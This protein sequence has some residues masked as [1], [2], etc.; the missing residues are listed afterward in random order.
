M[1]SGYDPD[2]LVGGSTIA[3]AAY[4]YVLCSEFPAVGGLNSAC[5]GIRKELC[6]AFFG[7]CVVILLIN[8]RKS[9]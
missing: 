6:R 4:L 2:L 5:E 3:E 1:G 8:L 9:R 7:V